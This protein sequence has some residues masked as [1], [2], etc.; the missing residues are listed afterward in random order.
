MLKYIDKFNKC[1]ENNI[2]IFKKLDILLKLQNKNINY[3]IWGDSYDTV[4]EFIKNQDNN[5]EIVGIDIEN[6]I[7][8]FVCYDEGIYN[9]REIEINVNDIKI[10]N[11]I[12]DLL[13]SY[14]I[15]YFINKDI[16]TSNEYKYTISIN[17]LKH[18]ITCFNIFINIILK[19]LI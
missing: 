7:N 11:K 13:K 4:S 1:V 16:D 9:S 8:I 6:N 14:K 18:T 3:I 15:N 17:S 10:K 5:L 19:E 2:N 12:I